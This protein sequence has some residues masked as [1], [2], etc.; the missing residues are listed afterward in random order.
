MKLTMPVPKLAKLFSW[1]GQVPRTFLR[2]IGVIDLAGGLG[3]LLPTLTHIVPQMT[4]FAAI[5]CTALQVLAIGFHARRGEI[6]ETPFNFF[7]LA[8]SVF[9][10]WGR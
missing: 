3:V 2:F 6:T 10:L 4:M 7:L 8:L 9:V 1:T 5:G